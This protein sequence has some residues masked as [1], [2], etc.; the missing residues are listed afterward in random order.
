MKLAEKCWAY[1]DARRGILRQ[2]EKQAVSGS[3][4]GSENGW[5]ETRVGI[6][7]MEIFYWK[8]W[9]RP[10]RRKARTGSKTGSRKQSRPV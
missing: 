10:E 7:G 8:E 2:E 9:N 4:A 1:A 5:I 3:K 6:E